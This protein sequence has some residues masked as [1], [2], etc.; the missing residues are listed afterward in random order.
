MDKFSVCLVGDGSSIPWLKYVFGKTSNEIMH[1]DN[2]QHHIED[3]IEWKPNI[4]FVDLPV[5]ELQEDGLVLATQ[6]EDTIFRLAAKCNCAIIIKTPLPPDLVDRL[7]R[8]NDKFVYSPDLK[9]E[10]DHMSER[11]SPQM[12]LLGASGQASMAVQEI[13]YRFGKATVAQ[14]AHVSPCEAAMIH[15]AQRSFHTMKK[16]FF[17]HLS[18]VCEEFDVDY[19]MI[20][21]YLQQDPRISGGLTRVPNYDGTR[22][23]A[24]TDAIKMLTRFNER[25]TLLKEVDKMNQVYLNREKVAQ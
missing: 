17:E 5:D 10:T 6:L 2:I 3:V 1:V 15:L 13:F 14:F 21:L 4:I 22:G 24:D 8:T 18:D 11:A 23:F 7:C 25:F 19:H 16:V 12:M 9:F 20:Q